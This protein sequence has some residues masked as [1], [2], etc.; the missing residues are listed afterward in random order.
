MQWFFWFVVSW[1]GVGVLLFHIDR[2]EEWRRGH[3]AAAA[4]FCP[5]ISICNTVAYA[6]QLCTHLSF[7]V[8]KWENNNMYVR[9]T[10]TVTTSIHSTNTTNNNKHEIFSFLC[11]RLRI[12]TDERHTIEFACMM[13]KLQGVCN[14]NRNN[15]NNDM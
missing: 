13:Y 10:H 1:I 5:F 4:D 9:N 6:D 8:Y 7:T 12:H 3:H 11:R 2:S 15:N 14:D